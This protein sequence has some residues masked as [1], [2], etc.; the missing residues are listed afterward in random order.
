MKLNIALYRPRLSQ[1]GPGTWQ[2]P[3][4]LGIKGYQLYLS[5]V[6]SGAEP[7]L[8]LEVSGGPTC[9]IPCGVEGSI[10]P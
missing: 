8:Q 2:M 9:S 5:C 1:G 7:M 6:M 10:A 3:V 4:A